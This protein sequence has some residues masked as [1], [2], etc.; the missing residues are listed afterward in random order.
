VAESRRDRFLRLANQRVNRAIKI[1]RL[2]G[3]LSVRSNYDYRD[4]DVRTITRALE[5]ELKA[6]KARFES[7]PTKQKDVFR[8]K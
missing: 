1:F 6:I 5:E 2:I 8:L 7:A 3:N 4:E